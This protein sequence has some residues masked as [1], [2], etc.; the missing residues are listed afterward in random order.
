MFKQQFYLNRL[1]CTLCSA[2]NHNKSIFNGLGIR[3]F[4]YKIVLPD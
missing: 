1:D 2:P 4:Q 3:D